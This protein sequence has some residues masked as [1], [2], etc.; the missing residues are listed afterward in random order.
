[1]RKPKINM[2]R[3]F[4]KDCKKN[5]I[6]VFNKSQI[7]KSVRDELLKNENIFS[8]YDNIYVLKKSDETKKQAI[9]NN[10][11]FILEKL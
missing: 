11:P 3:D 9:K 1:M 7:I 8:P 5:N 2:I 4:L 10:L 6:R